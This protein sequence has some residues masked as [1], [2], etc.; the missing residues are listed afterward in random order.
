MRESRSR[1]Y[2]R[3]PLTQTQTQQGQA[4]AHTQTSTKRKYNKVSH[5]RQGQ[6]TAQTQINNNAQIQRGNTPAQT[7]RV[8]STDETFTGLSH[9]TRTE[10]FHSLVPIL[11]NSIVLHFFFFPTLFGSD[12]LALSR[13]PSLPR[14]SSSLSLPISI[15]L[16]GAK[17]DPQALFF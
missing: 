8:G 1:G 6:A 10:A 13:H 12:T 5:L 9:N 4:I 15:S 14:P 11:S 7:S 17:V 3:L 16:L 2:R